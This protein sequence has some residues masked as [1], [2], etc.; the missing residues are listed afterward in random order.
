VQAPCRAALGLAAWRGAG[1]AAA[2]GAAQQGG[3]LGFFKKDDMVPEFAIAAFAMKDGQVS[4]VPVKTQFGWHVIQVIERRRAAPESF[5][6][7]REEL[8]QQVI[9]DGVRVAVARARA[10]VPVEKFNLDGSVPRATD[11]AEPPP[12]AR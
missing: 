1:A 5:E 2:T 7:A 4:A 8:R 10:I 9:Q 6:Q 12:A 3:D 11:S